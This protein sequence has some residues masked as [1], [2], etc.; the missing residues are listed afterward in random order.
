M[1]KRILYSVEPLGLD[2]FSM[3]FHILIPYVIPGVMKGL[4][5]SFTA[6]FVM[7]VFAEMLG[8]ASGLGYFIKLYSDYANYPNV[9]AGIILIAFWVLQMNK[10]LIWLEKKIVRW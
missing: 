3:T 7:L 4:K 2:A 6:S 8:A 10:L 9:V 5:V 1:D